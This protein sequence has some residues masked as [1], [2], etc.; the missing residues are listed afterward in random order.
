MKRII[1][2][3]NNNIKVEIMGTIDIK[4]TFELLNTATINVV[5]IVNK[6]IPKHRILAVFVPNTKD[7]SEANLIVDIQNRAFNI[8]V[9]DFDKTVNLLE[10][11]LNTQQNEF[12]LIENELIFFKHA[13]NATEEGPA[14]KNN[15]EESITETVTQTVEK[16]GVIN[17]DDSE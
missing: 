17:G 16:D 6:I 4:K 14:F 1:V 2:L 9:K 13:F 10:R 7:D 12:I 3:L 11:E 8:L 5:K 15:I